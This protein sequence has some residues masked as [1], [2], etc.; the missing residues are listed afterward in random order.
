MKKIIPVLIALLSCTVLIAQDAELRREID[1]DR[2]NIAFASQ[3]AYEKSREYIRKDSTYYI[4]YMYMGAYLFNRANDEKGFLQAITWLQ[5]AFDLIE[6]DYDQELRTRTND[7]VTYFGVSVVQNDYSYIGNWLETAY[8]NVEEAQKAYEVLIHI[9]ERDLQYESAVESW[10]TLAWL[11]HRNRMYTSEKF[12]FLKNSVRENDSMAYACLDS[13]IAK[14]HRDN[15]INQGLF[16]PQFMAA[17]Y[18]YT[19]HYKVILFTY[20]FELD[21]ADYYYDILLNSGY[22]SSNNYANYQYMKGEFGIAEQFYM[23][24]E[25]RDNT[26]EK[27][28]REYFYMRGLLEVYRAAPERAD[29][30]L[31]RVI[32]KDGFTPGYGWHS[33]ALARS[34]MYE[35]LTTVSQ[36]KLNNAARFEELHIGTTWGREQYTLSVATLN[37]INALRFEGEYYFE[38]D[39]WLFWLNPVNWYKAIEYKIKVHHFRLI[40][41]SLIASNPERAEVIYPL[42]SSENLLGWDETWQMLDGFSNEYF[43]GVYEKMLDEDPRP[44]VRNYIRFMLARLHMSEGDEDLARPYLEEIYMETGG[45]ER[46]QFDN[47]LYARTCEAMAGITEGEESQDWLVKC[48]DV[49][50]Q[51]VPFSGEE[52]KFRIMVN[53]EP[54]TPVATYT[55]LRVAIFVLIDIF[56]L[57][58]LYF[59]AR[60]YF[61]LRHSPVVFVISFG[62]I[63]TACLVVILYVALTDNRLSAEEKIMAGFQDCN[64]GYTDD[65]DA[66][67][68]AFEFVEKDSLLNVEYTVHN[69][70]HQLVNSGTITI[71]SDNPS[72]TGI[73]LAYR[74]FKIDFTYSST[75]DVD[76]EEVDEEAGDE[77]LSTAEEL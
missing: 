62:V 17:R 58:G 69:S 71:D 36:R 67:V 39:D 57:A 23:E 64:V 60:Y 59:L 41:V 52:L 4:G 19:Y 28:T 76:A 10:N 35:G 33:I 63:F 6:R 30:L 72:R 31:S 18:Y 45:P 73:V 65:E 75:S 12:P 61:R 34:L 74:L 15:E 21:S 5:K 14:T 7:L 16:D 53:G 38:N 54:Y 11:Y 46:M 22:Y 26:V 43:I 66:P 8:Q 27:H 13:A 37:Y 32:S 47:L 20:D 29:S 3:Q 50:P 25:D 44:G 1:I 68:A 48:Y 51:L 9:K 24:A 56:I 70:A 2:R 42:F 40:M 49:Y 77:Q 55:M